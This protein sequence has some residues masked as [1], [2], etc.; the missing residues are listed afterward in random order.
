MIRLN[1]TSNLEQ[2]AND[3]AMIKIDLQ[4]AML[5]ASDKVKISFMDKLANQDEHAVKNP[6]VNI[7][8]VDN[9]VDI[10]ISGIDEDILSYRYET[11]MEDLVDQLTEEFYSALDSEIR[12]MFS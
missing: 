7:I 12:G 4:Q 6:Q 8:P 3:F 1:V 9:S 5:S 2:M 10:Q 11:S